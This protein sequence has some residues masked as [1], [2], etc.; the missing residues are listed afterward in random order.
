MMGAR[1]AAYSFKRNSRSPQRFDVRIL[2]IRDF[3]RLMEP[4]QTL[5]REGVE[6]SWDPDDLQSFTPLRFAPPELMGF[7]GRALVTD[8][9][10]FA[11]AD[12][13]ELLDREMD[14]K[15]ILAACRPRQKGETP[16]FASSVMLLDCARLRH[17]K[18]DEML[19]GLFG[20]KFDYIAWNRLELEDRSTIGILDP[21]WN[22]FD[23]LTSRTRILHTTKRRTQ[24]WKSGLPVD[25]R[26]YGGGLLGLAG[27]LRRPRYKKHPDQNQ[28]ALVYSLLAEMIDKGLVTKD[29]LKRETAANHMRHDSLEL[30]ERY[31]GW[32]FDRSPAATGSVTFA[33]PAGAHRATAAS[34]RRY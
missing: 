22:D 32:E 29:E 1:I 28:E 23:T 31:R 17:W 2:D 25:Y 12:C 27:R 3:P 6:R 11:V 5:I 24:P 4:G 21:E 33:A 18:F 16:F 7:E 34:S 13:C 10:C 30:I 19:D 9:D 15:A 26:W 8:P 20:H 14:G